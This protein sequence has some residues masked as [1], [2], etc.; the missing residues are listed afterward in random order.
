MPILKK[1]Q[2]TLAPAKTLA[3][4]F[5]LIITVGALLL[6][7]PI[8]SKS[9]EI[10]AWEDCIFTA[11]S[12]TCV[13]GIS[14]VDTYSHWNI[15]GQVIIMLLI[16]VGGL[17]FITLVTFF[18]FA[19]GRKIGFLQASNISE[20]LTLTG[21]SATKK[22]FY[23][24]VIFSFAIETIGA[25]LFMI[26]LVPMYGGYGVFMSFFTAVS[27]FCNAGFDLF[28][29]EGAGVG[30]SIFVDDPYMLIVTAFLII[31][32]GLGFVIWEELVSYKKTKKFSL[33]TK[34]VLITTTILIIGGTIGYMVVEATESELF[35]EYTPVQRL[36][37]SFFASVSSRTAGFSAAPLP[38]A[39][40]FS[41]MFTI[42]LM[43]IG[44]APGSTGGGMKVTTVAI[45]V[46]TAIS[47]LKGQ[48]DTQMFRHRV[49]KQVVYKTLTT[50]CLAILFIVTG[51]SIVHLLNTNWDS[52]DSLFEVVSAFSTTGFSS[53]ISENSDWL[54]KV[55]LSF[56]MYIGRIGPVS[57]MLSFT[58]KNLKSKSEILPYGE[59]MVG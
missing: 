32:G 46:A 43:L 48:E 23:R 38:T 18:N 22:I 4:G 11:A 5:F 17:G 1:K 54:T 57:F 16:Q 52:L 51:F 31:I 47:V 10:T 29:I 13:T 55:I 12:A 42:I 9:G 59:I 56:I 2:K 26:R 6:A 19:V 15:F 34:V 8:S 44:T 30:M 24:V 28:G 7:L 25:C 45:I 50:F 36:T 3:L 35:K 41:K 37:T 27:A 40:S 14:V 21:L 33:H 49:S 20:D 53:G 39:G 58:G